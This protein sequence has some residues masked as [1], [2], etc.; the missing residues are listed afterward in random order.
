MKNLLRK[1]K[2]LILEIIGNRNIFF[3][4]LRSLSSIAPFSK[5]KLLYYDTVYARMRAN[6]FKYL[7]HLKEI[8]NISYLLLL[9]IPYVIKLYNVNQD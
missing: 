3:I 8:F 2:F 6:K 5:K 1:D 9:Y 7:L 4:L